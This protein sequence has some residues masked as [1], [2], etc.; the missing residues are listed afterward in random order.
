MKDRLE[1]FVRENRESFDHKA[2][3]ADLWAKVE[4]GL[5]TKHRRLFPW[6]LLS[7]AAGLMILLGLVGTWAF[8]QGMQQGAVNSLAEISS[9]FGEVEKH[10]QTEIK[11][12]MAQLASFNKEDEVKGDIIEM[13]EFLNELKSDLKDTPKNER[14]VVIQAMIANYRSRVDLLERVLDRLQQN[15]TNKLSKDETKSI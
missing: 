10:Y 1:K 13:D 9:E 4:A 15:S 14:D 7:I 2:P 8:K 6:R 12:K 11:N 3:P 5:P